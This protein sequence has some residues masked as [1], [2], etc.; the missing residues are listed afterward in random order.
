MYN[1][2]FEGAAWHGSSIMKILDRVTSEHIK[3]DPQRSQRIAKVV[4]HM[5]TWRAFSIHVL[6]GGNVYDVSEEDNWKDFDA[7]TDEQWQSL[8][9]KLLATQNELNALLDKMEDKQLDEKVISKQYDL[10]ILL[11]GMIQHDLYH[12]GEITAITQKLM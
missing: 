8:K 12:L 3:Q 1:N 10:Y 6:K 11:H 2:A 7:L 9:S 4:H 5:L